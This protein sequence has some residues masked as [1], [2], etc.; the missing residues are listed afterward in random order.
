MAYERYEPVIGLE[1]HVQL[2]TSAKIF[3]PDAAA[4]GAAPNTQVDPI[5]LGHPGTLPV[6]NET[7]V[8]H[9]LRLGVATHCSIAARSAFARKH[10][11]Y[12]DLPKG[13]QISQYD[14]PI[15][16]DGYL[17]VFPG[18][19]EDASPSAPDSRR[20]GLTRIHMEE[21]AGKSVHASAGGS[22][23]LDYNRCGV[24]LLEM[25]TEPDLRSPRE[26]ALFL[27]RLRQLV[28]YLGISDGNMEEGSLRCDANVSVR[29]QGREA[30]GTRTELKNMNSMRHV[31][32]ALDY[33]I[34]RQIAAAERGESITQQTL[35]W[36]ADAGMTRPMRSKEEAHDYRYLPDPDLVEVRIEDATIDEVRAN[37]PELPRARRRRFVE[38]VGLPAYDA[39]VLTEERAVADYF[40]EA[41][42]HLYKRTKGG[43]TDAQA[44]A[45]SNFIMT[46]V[47]R[48]LNERGLPIGELGV[49]P[50]RLA[51]LVFLRLQDK[52]SS[53]GAQEV[54]EAMLDAPDKSAGRIADERDLIQVTDRGAIAPVVE[55]VLSDNPDK[56]NTYLGGKDGLL[57]FFIGQVMQRFDGSP[58][59]EL[60]RSLLREKLD[61]RRDTANVD[62]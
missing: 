29:P 16:Y 4:F 38:E 32:Q 55:D 52:V 60:V 20:V 40:E 47:M 8:K 46:E 50:E 9:A 45:V 31:E 26:A 21:D 27:Q 6:L 5:S 61:A 56:V 62:E 59:P 49:G 18:E 34:A 23:R 41:L 53:N 37:L 42:R 3:S 44:K 54:F 10:Y 2:Q 35:L 33:E 57:G 15:C 19:E 43:D 30:F 48:V 36:D 7:V 28:R 14:T 1:V 58:N 13:Y 24:P 17:E 22:T 39:G 25:V 12:P 11:F 51:Q